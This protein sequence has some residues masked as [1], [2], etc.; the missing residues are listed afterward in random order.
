[1]PNLP[2]HFWKTIWTKEFE[3]VLN[4]SS[5]VWNPFIRNNHSIENYSKAKTSVKFSLSLN[6]WW[7]LI[8]YTCF[9]SYS[10]GKNSTILLIWNLLRNAVNVM[11]IVWTASC[12]KYWFYTT[13]TRIKHNLFFARII[14]CGCMVLNVYTEIVL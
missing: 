11:N 1:M 4:Y 2:F 13:I 9:K 3:T 5:E 10:F 12:S 7:I 6:Y 14:D 8:F